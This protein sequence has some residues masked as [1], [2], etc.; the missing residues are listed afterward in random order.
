MY[1]VNP[2][3]A[4]RQHSFARGE[5]TPHFRVDLVILTTSSVEESARPARIMTDFSFLELDM[6]DRPFSWPPCYFAGPCD[7]S[8]IGGTGF[9]RSHPISACLAVPDDSVAAVAESR[10]GS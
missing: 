4:L 9:V 10:P 6:P 8:S 2:M 3:G 5:V 1:E 7:C